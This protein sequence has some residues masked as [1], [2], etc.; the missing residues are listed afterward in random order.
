MDHEGERPD[1]ELSRMLDRAELPRAREEFKARLRAEF[2][3]GE[4]MSD[5]RAVPEPA[6]AALLDQEQGPS[7]R[8]EFKAGLKARFVGATESAAAPPLDEVPRVARAE[9]RRLRL[10]VGGIA[11]AAMIAVLFA[12]GVF[13]PSR[14]RWH[15]LSVDFAELEIDGERAADLTGPELDSRLSR[16]RQVATGSGT[17]RMEYENRFVLELGEHTV[18]GLDRMPDTARAKDLVL[19]GSAGSFRVATGP[20]FS[21]TELQFATSLFDAHVTGTVF[22]IDVLDE[23][24]CLCVTEGA[25]DLVPSLGAAPEHHAVREGRRCSVDWMGR[26]MEDTVCPPH[27]A[28]LE[29]LAL[30]YR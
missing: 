11:A 10:L 30:D 4:S 20:E 17:F 1:G 21:G 15:A 12:Q 18:L 19:V 5:A 28:P 3:S 16:A 14:P 24:I 7:A 22:G 29:G 6:L 9:R 13:G 27:A 8:A 26:T 23:G 2:V 25:V